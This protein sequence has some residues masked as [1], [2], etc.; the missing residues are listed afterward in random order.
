MSPAFVEQLF[1]LVAFSVTSF[2]TPGP[3]NVMLLTSGVNHGFRRTIPH[4]TGVTIGFSLMTVLV[5][6]G[7]GSVFRAA[8]R[9]HDVVEVIGV[10]YLLWLSWKIATA[11]TAQ[12]ISTDGV[13]TAAK[14]FTFL[15]AAAF[16]WVNAKGWVM[17]VSVVSIWVP[18]G[19]EATRWIALIFAIF[20]AIGAASSATW[21]ALGSMIAR[22]FADPARLRLFNIAMAVLL[23]ASLWPAFRDIAGWLRP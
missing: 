22:W 23:V 17:V 14:P 8:P 2:F 20:I 18:E 9:I 16:Q 4:M 13:A 21:A 19:P 6:F 5:A 15:Q 11:P 7:L 1:A 10:L 12:G 3:N